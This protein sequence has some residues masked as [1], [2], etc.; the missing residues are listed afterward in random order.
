[1]L[2]HEVKILRSR[3][4]AAEQWCRHNIGFETGDRPWYMTR[5]IN[6]YFYFKY[7]E[8]ATLFKLKWAGM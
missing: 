6:C 8:D 2:Y 4:M 1:M 5:F 7:P 3:E